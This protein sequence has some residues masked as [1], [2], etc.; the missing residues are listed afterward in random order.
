MALDATARKVSPPK[1]PLRLLFRQAARHV[2]PCSIRSARLP[3]SEKS[4]KNRLAPARRL[5][6][7]GAELPVFDDQPNLSISHISFDLTD[8][9]R[10][11]ATTGDVNIS[12][13]PFNGAGVYLSNDGGQSWH[14]SGLEDTGVLSKV[15]VDPNNPEMI[16][17]GSMGYP[18]SKGNERGLF[19]SVNAGAT[20]QKTLTVSMTV[21]VLLIL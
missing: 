18:S 4:V 9:D 11:W 16:Y 15:V 12:G 21:Q 20:W 6:P 1:N 7:L 2:L 10:V 5:I 14:Y 19:R 8:P 13:Y 3:P 17:V